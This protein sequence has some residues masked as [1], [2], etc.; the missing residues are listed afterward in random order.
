MKRNRFSVR[1]EHKKRRAGKSKYA[2]KKESGQQMYGPGCCA[3]SLH[4]TG[5]HR[6]R[7]AQACRERDYGR[8]DHHEGPII[9]R[10]EAA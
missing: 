1:A 4:I 5:E 7:W 9:I 8:R 2:A 6:A 3:N 10:P